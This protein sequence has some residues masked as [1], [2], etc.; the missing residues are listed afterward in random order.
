MRS[1]WCERVLWLKKAAAKKNKRKK[2]KIHFSYSSCGHNTKQIVWQMDAIFYF[3][4]SRRKWTLSEILCC[5]NIIFMLG[6]ALSIRVL[7]ADCWG[8]GGDEEKMRKQKLSKESWRKLLFMLV[9]KRCNV[10]K[11]FDKK[12]IIF[13]HASKNALTRRKYLFT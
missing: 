12:K 5:Q 10:D 6:R 7:R 4:S 11:N 1:W 13:H 2:K 9:R 3:V 8:E